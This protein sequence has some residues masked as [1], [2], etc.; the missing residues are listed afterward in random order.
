MLRE[1]VVQDVRNRV[2]DRSTSSVRSGDIDVDCVEC[3]HEYVDSFTI[4]Q[5]TA[6]TFG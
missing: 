1:S 6:R 4:S 2:V 5:E 3:G